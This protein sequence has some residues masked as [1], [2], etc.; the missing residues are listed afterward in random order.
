[1]KLSNF[2]SLLLTEGIT[3]TANSSA[4]ANSASEFSDVRPTEVA[5]CHVLSLNM[6]ERAALENDA[7]YTIDEL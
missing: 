7:Q 1:M 3:V 2:I 6:D 4:L 5:Q